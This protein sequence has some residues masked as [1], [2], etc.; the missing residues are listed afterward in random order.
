M[1]PND[2]FNL[3]PPFPRNNTVFVVMSFAAEFDYRWENVI[4]P[5][6]SSVQEN[7][8]ALS[9]ER[10]DT[11]S[12][13]DSILTEILQHIGN[14][15]LVFADITI[16][17][18]LDSHPIR[19]GNVMYEVGIAH[20]A[21]LPEEVVLFRSDTDPLLF[22]VA[23]VRVNTYAPDDDPEDARQ[24]VMNATTEALR[25]I[26]SKKH[27][28]VKLAT[29]SLDA[30]AWWVLV[31]AIQS[32]FTTMHRRQSL[33]QAIGAD[34]HNQAIT[35]LLQIGALSTDYP[36]LSADFLQTRGREPIEEIIKY[37]ITNFGRAIVE[38][39]F[40]EMG[41]NNPELQDAID[42]YLAE[43]LT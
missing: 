33:A 11:R 25:E 13:G 1:Y 31:S 28:A 23:N 10:A 43:G 34:P 21:R 7:G 9:A 16:I 39:A 18:H 26:G 35:R 41:A 12:I 32:G 6:I 4:K 38:S 36:V 20:A 15:R 17:G 14:A 19:N 24:T 5:A 40:A 42:T 8:I 2:Y 30:Y 27:L 37:N 3:F 29:Q 22:D